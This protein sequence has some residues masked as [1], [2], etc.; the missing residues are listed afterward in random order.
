[1]A[2]NLSNSSDINVTTGCR[3]NS[4]SSME[5]N[6]LNNEHCEEVG[7]TILCG[8]FSSDNDNAEVLQVQNEVD[9]IDSQLFEYIIIGKKKP[10]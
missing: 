8:E 1:M 6:V 7:P 4:E 10:V 3:G 9:E 5:Y 2:R